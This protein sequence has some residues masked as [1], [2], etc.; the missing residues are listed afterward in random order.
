MQ[1][2]GE[3]YTKEQREDLYT[4]YEKLRAEDIRLYSNIKAAQ[5]S[6]H[7]SGLGYEVRVEKYGKEEAEK[8]LAPLMEA[9]QMRGESIKAVSAFRR[10]HE[11]IAELLNAKETVGTW[12]S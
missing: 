8:Q 5:A 10:D 11:I 7:D 2:A 3:F 12:T 4:T 6:L 9:N 1:L